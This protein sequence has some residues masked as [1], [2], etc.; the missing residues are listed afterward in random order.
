[1]ESS[2][3]TNISPI[4]PAAS[5]E[6]H[7]GALKERIGFT[8]T[9]ALIVFGVGPVKRVIIEKQKEWKDVLTSEELKQVEEGK[10]R[11]M[12]EA[13]YFRLTA[14]GERIHPD[15]CI[16]VE[17][18][19][20][21][22]NKNPQEMGRKALNYWSRINALAVG[23]LLLSGF[24]DKLILTGGKTAGDDF[25][26]E[27]QLMKDI[28]IRGFGTRYK[29]KYGQNIE[30]VIFMEEKSKKTYEN[31]IYALNDFV[32]KNSQS[33]KKVGL[34]GVNYQTER[35]LAV[36]RLFGLTAE[37]SYKSGDVLKAR[38]KVSKWDSFAAKLD[39]FLDFEKNPE[40]YRR[41]KEE[42]RY[43][44]GLALPEYMKQ[45]VRYAGYIENPER[46]KSIIERLQSDR[47]RETA[48]GVL[49]NY[50]I[51]IDS[52]T[53]EQIDRM[54]AEELEEI[55]NKFKQIPREDMPPE[56]LPNVW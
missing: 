45:W 56:Y 9:D 2:A 26:S 53:M 20:D 50:G 46:L 54:E 15:N 30:E 6:G 4:S 7:D 10:K 17:E 44:A 38:L 24:T 27:A 39:D 19:G 49:R 32:D 34:L 41:I 14:K 1:M 35:I 12:S 55:R 18:V 52:L 23:E 31:F 5:A 3:A 42:T 40:L 11:V 43:D 29:E 33:F 37:A 13:E 21:I 25:S 51:D 36:G 28:I 16:F 47:W 48:N 22:Y 8:K